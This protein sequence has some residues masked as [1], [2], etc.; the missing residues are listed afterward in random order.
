MMGLEVMPKAQVYSAKEALKAVCSIRQ[1]QLILY[2]GQSQCA[3]KHSQGPPHSQYSFNVN[4]VLSWLEAPKQCKTHHITQVH[5]RP[6]RELRNH[7]D[8]SQVNINHENS[9]NMK[10][11]QDW[12]WAVGSSCPQSWETG[13]LPGQALLKRVAMKV[14]VATIQSYLVSNLPACCPWVWHYCLAPCH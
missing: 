1:P 10:E 5:P 12:R 3:A 14:I 8:V 7:K 9:Q 2:L 4:T 6:H 13:I 11:T